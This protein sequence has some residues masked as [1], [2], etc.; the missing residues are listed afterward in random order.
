[1]QAIKYIIRDL[2]NLTIMS[3]NQTETIY[4]VDQLN[5][6]LILQDA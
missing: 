4:D 2:S 6:S 5:N 1:M 3:E